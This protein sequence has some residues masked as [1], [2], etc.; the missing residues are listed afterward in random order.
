VLIAVNELANE[1]VHMLKRAI[2]AVSI[3]RVFYIGRVSSTP[4]AV[5]R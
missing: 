3:L 2:D 4:L 1:K 5:P